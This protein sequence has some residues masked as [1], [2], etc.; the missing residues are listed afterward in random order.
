[1]SQNN[2]PSNLEGNAILQNEQGDVVAIVT[3]INKTDENDIATAQ[4][5]QHC[6]STDSN[7]NA[8][9]L[10]PLIADDIKPDLKE[11]TKI[12]DIEET[13]IDGNEMPNLTL[14][15]QQMNENNN[16]NMNIPPNMSGS[17]IPELP[18]QTQS[19]WTKE[20][21]IVLKQLM[22]SLPPHDIGAALRVILDTYGARASKLI[23]RGEFVE[24]DL[25]NV[26]DD[27]ILD[28][29][30]NYCAQM[31]FNIVNTLQQ[32]QV[33]SMPQQPQY[34][35]YAPTPQTPQTQQQQPMYYQQVQFVQQQQPQQYVQQMPQ[36]QHQQIPP[37]MQ[38]MAPQ[39]QND[40][41]MQQQQLYM[42]QMQAP[43]INDQDN[44]NNQQNNMQ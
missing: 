37:Q 30:W 26:N 40:Q 18:P 13:K 17:E 20:N 6:L 28:S 21:R 22:G 9:I 14:D 7:Q 11:E 35:T 23:R 31:Q 12:Q 32:Q 34:C 41:V 19:R 44:N 42:Q 33:Q 27:F 3:D 24:L 4:S 5:Q 1:M 8:E 36:Q 43:I 16:N 39:I 38:Q 29:L 10:P 25:M 2:S 15:Q